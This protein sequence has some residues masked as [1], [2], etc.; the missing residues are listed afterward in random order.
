MASGGWGVFLALQAAVGPL[1]TQGTPAVCSAFLAPG[2]A[3]SPAVLHTAAHCLERPGV[4]FW[5]P[6]LAGDAARPGQS[7]WT[8]VSALPAAGWTA[9][10]GQDRATRPW[11]QPLPVDLPGVAPLPPVGT[12]LRVVGYP[13]GK[14]PRT[15]SCRYVGVAL[16]AAPASVPRIRPSLAC[17][18]PEG[19]GRY[20]GFSG[21]P[22][23]TADGRV[24]GVLAS[25]T[26]S[27]SG[28]V[29]PGFEPLLPWVKDGQS[30]H[31]A[32]LPWDSQ[33]PQWL[34]V[35]IT[36]GQVRRFRLKNAAGV[37]WTEG[38]SVARTPGR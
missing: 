7:Q 25:G 11:T 6:G 9:H 19:V 22:V 24:V 31:R 14:G 23:L 8:T 38:P 1:V 5:F 29:R 28:D 35:W 37:V 30:M 27:A 10:A 12:P 18:R 16:L 20:T 21:G 15:L 17:D 3:G 26:T 2:A 4:R 36:D 34:E 13:E 33:D 32:A